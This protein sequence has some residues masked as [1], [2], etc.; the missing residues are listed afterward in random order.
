MA[1]ILRPR[2]LL[3]ALLSLCLGVLGQGC[4]SYGVDYS[5][6]GS[7]Y[8]DGSSNQYF[9]FVSVFSGCASELVSPV[10]VSPDNNQYACSA[11][12][13][14][15]S[16]AQVTSQCG[17]PFSAMKSGTW[18]I[19][20]AG[21]QIAA[22]RTITLNVGIP[23]TT[24][25][26]A[27]PTV[28]VGVTSTPR[29]VTVISTI[30]Q[31]Q[32][33][34]LVPATV[35]SAACNTGTATVTIYPQGQTVTITSTVTRTSTQGTV[36]SQYTT[37]VTTTAVCHYSNKKRDVLKARVAVA[38]TT[39]TVTQTT[40]TVTRSVTTTLPASTTTEALLR[41]TTRTITPAPSTVCLGPGRPSVTVTV[42]VGNPI[43]VTQTNIIYRTVTSQ[44][45]VWL[46]RT[47]ISTSTNAASA[48]A[49]WRAGGWYGL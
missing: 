40:F 44:G 8:I 23:Q 45:T 11:I 17:I 12:Q 9:S 48:T 4:T 38:A 42:R 39:V 36:T 33:L 26:T 14:G 21:N 41:I 49:C 43:A 1:V 6:G 27:T 29:A 5:N 28:I 19:V 7:Y 34:I 30:V 31:T 46:G 22:Q 20:V 35:T 24:T 25:I 3:A 10:L 37:T 15:Q 13:T 32:T 18:R 16:G 2:L 47:V